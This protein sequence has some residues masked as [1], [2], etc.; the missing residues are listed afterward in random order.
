MIRILVFGMTENPGGVESFLL[1]YYRKLD[2]TRVQLDFLGNSHNP[3]A[4]EEELRQLGARTF[5]VAARSENF[6]QYRREMEELFAAHAS[7][8]AAIWVNVSSLAN[9]DYLILAKKYGIPRRIIHSHNSRNMDSRLRGA[10]HYRNRQIID[11]YATDFFACS[12][13]AADWFYTGKVRQRAV[14]IHNAIDV[15]RLF[16]TEEKRAQIRAQIGVEGAT[17]VVGNVGRL[18]FQKNQTFLLDVFAQLHQ[19]HP[20]SRLVLVGQGEDEEKLRDHA[21]QLGLDNSVTFAGVQYDVPAWL[22]AFD[23]FLFPSLFEGLPIAALEAQANGVPVLAST[24]AMPRESVLCGNVRRLSLRRTA[25]QWADTALSLVRAGRE[26]ESEV[27]RRFVEGG[28][29]IDTEAGKLQA[30]LLEGG[31]GRPRVQIVE[32]SESFAHAGSKATADVAQIAEELGYVRIPVRMVT[33]KEG[34][35]A[36][37]QRQVGFAA[38]WAR[39]LEKVPVGAEVLLQHPF[40]YPQLTRE[41]TLRALKEKK[42]VRFLCLVHDV[43]ELRGFRYNDYYRREFET[44]LELCD[45]LIVHNRV[46]ADFFV[47]RGVPQEKIVSLEIFDY[48]QKGAP[49]QR[50]QFSRSITV[51]GN[52]D[53]IKCGYVAGLGELSDVQVDL[54]GVNFDESMRA[55]ENVTYHGAFPAD[56]IPTKLTRGFGLVWDGSSVDGCRGESGQYLRYNNPHKL[57]LYLSSGLPVV[58]WSQAAE[59]DFVRRH[60]VGLCVDSLRDLGAVLAGIDEER[61]AQIAANVAEL[62]QKL[63]AGDFARAA[64]RKAQEKLEG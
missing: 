47:G 44:M 14:I 26:K 29:D 35:L 46:M 42:H 41:A 21:R 11:R 20:D 57:S 7:E 56:V 19:K 30:R 63:R 59:A 9:I 5:H 18:H 23:L 37:A 39:A 34:K 64:I 31:S 45:V 10:L 1:G 28:Y 60:D 48:L 13:S 58:I 2:R 17:L 4:Y 15:S 24:A 53:T 51:A 50:P 62:G 55:C 32:I 43:E 40:H 22:S 3:M 16:Y 36:K 25:E 38:D 61:Y 8:Y 33:T 12:E 6:S 27:R 54:Y 52:L 49:A